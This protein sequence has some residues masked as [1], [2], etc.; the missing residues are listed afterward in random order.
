MN[1][2]SWP[3]QTKRT[4]A[5]EHEGKYMVAKTNYNLRKQ[6]TMNQLTSRINSAREEFQNKI[7]SCCQAGEGQ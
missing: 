3:Y 6:E 5:L 2:L 1:N 7:G 4:C